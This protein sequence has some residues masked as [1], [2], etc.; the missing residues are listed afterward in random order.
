MYLP[1]DLREVVQSDTSLKSFGYMFD[2]YYLYLVIV[3]W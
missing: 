1:S 2:G 3:V